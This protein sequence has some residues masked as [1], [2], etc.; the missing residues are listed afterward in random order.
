M[1]VTEP[2]G[3]LLPGFC[4]TVAVKVIPVPTFT[5]AA[6]AISA[7][8]VGTRLT[9][10]VTA[11]DVLA[12]LLLS[13]PYTAVIECGPTAS[14]AVANA[15][16]PAPFSVP[17]P[18]I[19]APSIKVTV[20]VG[21]VPPVGGVTVAVNVTVVPTLT[22]VALAVSTFVLVAEFTVT[23]LAPVALVYV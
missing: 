2:V 10:T 8:D 15:A 3:T 19:A 9:V 1:N 20:P 18:S 7:V 13:P 12:A 23:E 22:L 16:T 17:V 11:F 5:L 4:V 14:V 21:V 6:L